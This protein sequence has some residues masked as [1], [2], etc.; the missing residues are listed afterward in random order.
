MTVTKNCRILLAHS[1]NIIQEARDKNIDLVLA[2][3]THGGQVYIRFDQ[4]YCSS[5]AACRTGIY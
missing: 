2:G 4:I 3:H 5:K 1:P